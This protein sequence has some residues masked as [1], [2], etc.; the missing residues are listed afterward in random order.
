MNLA[1]TGRVNKLRA[2]V[3]KLIEVSQVLMPIQMSEAERLESI[4]R[5]F[6]L[7]LTERATD[8]ADTMEIEENETNGISAM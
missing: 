4:T 2:E 5:A 1:A 3:P 8:I 6:M 7:V